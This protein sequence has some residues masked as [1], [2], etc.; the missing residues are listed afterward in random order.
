M[1]IADV[2]R[3]K[4]SAVHTA[5]PSTP[6]AEVLATLAARNVGALVIVENR[7]VRGLV[8]ERDVV[9]SISERGPGLLACQ[10]WEI[11]TTTP[12]HCAPEDPVDHVMRLMTE[13]RFRHV[14]VLVDGRLAGLV[15]I[16]DMVAARIGE[17]E[18]ERA[19]L[20]TYI[21]HG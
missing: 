3:H 2:L 4:G 1:R 12:V 10:V 18:Q 17:L 8:S 14:P 13:H 5:L 21:A 20:E 6:V 11:M 7:T 19:Y 9:R 15:S 16:G